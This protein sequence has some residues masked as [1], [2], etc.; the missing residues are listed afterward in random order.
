MLSWQLSIIPCN[1]R[2]PPWQRNESNADN[3]RL[4]ILT[5]NWG[6]PKQE[7]HSG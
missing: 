2:E 1:L 4:P 5:V 7:R 6:Y 3:P